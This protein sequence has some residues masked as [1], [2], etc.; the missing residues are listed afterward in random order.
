MNDSDILVKMANGAKG[1]CKDCAFRKGTDANSNDTKAVT[2]AIHAILNE[3]PFN[4]H[5]SNFEDRGILCKGYEFVM[6]Q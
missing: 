6:N 5:T 2:M 4:C 3:Y 1:M